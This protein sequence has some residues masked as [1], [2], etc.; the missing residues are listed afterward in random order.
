MGRVTL[1]GAGPGDPGLITVKG[2]QRLAEADVVVYDALANPRLLKY[3]REG[4]ELI[5]AG[6]R[7]AGESGATRCRR[8]RSIKGWSILQNRARM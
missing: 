3:L 8:M 1:I 7:G 6:K 2:M 4:K 5:Y